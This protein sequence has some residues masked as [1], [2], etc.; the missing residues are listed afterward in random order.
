[1]TE[2]YEFELVF[3][4]PKGKYDPFEL[5][6]AVFEA[7]FEDA[8]VG[9]GNARLLSVELEAAGGDA[10]T[11]MLAAAKAILKNLPAGTELREVRP[12]L[13]SQADVAGKLGISKQSLQKK[14]MP[15]PVT[16]GLY[17]IDEMEEALIREEK[18][19]KR[20][21][22]FQVSS[23]RNWF[24]AGQAARRLN[25]RIALKTLDSYSLEEADPAPKA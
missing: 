5:S 22:R 24:R 20:S 8:V 23:A 21:P 3:G 16:A 13:V 18:T 14:E 19:A 7:G 11:A 12:D 4:L 1:M 6:D 2:R 10:E 17:R 15:L 9:T 25:A